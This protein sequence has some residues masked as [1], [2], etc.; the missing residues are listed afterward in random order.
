M[1]KLLII[2]NR[3]EI[4]KSLALAQKYNLGFEYND[5]FTPDVLDDTS[6]CKQY[7][8]EYQSHK[9]PDFCTMHGDFFDVS[10]TSFDKKI[11]EISALRINQSIDIAKKMKV[12]AIIFHINYNP[13]LNTRVYVD[14][15]ISE[16]IKFWG[17]VLSQNPDIN[18][19]LENMFEQSPDILIEI[20]KELCHFKNFGI[21]LDFAHA[22]ISKTSAH[23][24]V[25]K[26]C[27]YIR[28]IHIN[29]NDL[30]SDLHL[31]WGDGKINRQE[32]YSLYEKYLQNTPILIETSS[33]D[34]QIR[35]L[36][37]LIA[38]RFIEK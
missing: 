14:N 24:W 25:E 20:A 5:F 6:L 29:D 17:E 38:D 36:E 3:C 33:I 4:K 37:T 2:P 34:N 16:N 30:T 32:F 15:F 9:L 10:V 11:R 35:S 12:S 26:L 19:Y 31:A 23:I 7:I 8:T 1:K 27:P 22:S 21:C 28:H 13:F 18:I